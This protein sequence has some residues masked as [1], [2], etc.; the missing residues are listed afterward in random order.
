MI[1][2]LSLRALTATLA[3]SLLQRTAFAIEIPKDTPLSS[4]L[5]SAT[6][7]LAQ[8]NFNEALTYLDEAVARDPQNYLTVFKRGAA[9]LSL[10]RNSQASLDFDR[11]LDLK[12]GFEGALIQRAKLKSRSGDWSG[13]RADYEAAGKKDSTEVSELVEA[14]EAATKAESAAEAQD[15]ESCVTNA[16]TAIRIA[17]GQAILRRLRAKCRLEKGEVHEAIG[18]LQHLQQLIPGSTEPHLQSTALLFYSLGDT[19]RALTQIRKCLHSDPDSKPCKKLYSRIR[20]LEKPLKKLAET[21]EK[22]QYAGA[23]KILIGTK[24][25]A[26]LI[27]KVKADLAELKADSIINDKAPMELLVMLVDSACEVYT[28][29]KKHS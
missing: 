21:K 20:K 15:W 12:P 18:D 7:S 5:S 14:H 3:V 4:L 1:I 17:S 28:E 26:G 11:V 16:G 19:D 13:A 2:S 10:G 23:S 27:D 8:G 29:V 6:N 24:D 25:E 9:Y 22:Q